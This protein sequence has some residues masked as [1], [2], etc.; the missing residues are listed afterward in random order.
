MSTRL[1]PRRV[2][3]REI[4]RIRGREDRLTNELED[5][6]AQRARWETVLEALD[7]DSHHEPEEATA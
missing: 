5:A 7:G 6:Q 1:T 2:A 3:E 4:E